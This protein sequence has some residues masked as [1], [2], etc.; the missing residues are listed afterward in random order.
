MST[1][2]YSMTEVRRLHEVLSA[3]F[4]DGRMNYEPP[5]EGV[6]WK[7]QFERIDD[8]L[9]AKEVANLGQLP[10]TALNVPPKEC[11]RI[12]TLCEAPR[13]AIMWW[14]PVATRGAMGLGGVQH[15]HVA[16]MLSVERG[17]GPGRGTLLFNSYKPGKD[18]VVV[19]KA[20]LA[21][22]KGF[23]VV[24]SKST[25][26]NAL[27]PLKAV[28]SGLSI[29]ADFR[30]GLTLPFTCAAFPPG[31]NGQAELEQLKGHLESLFLPLVGRSL[32][33]EDLDLWQG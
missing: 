28:V 6:C 13:P 18:G 20:E 32:T 31:V 19:V 26:A 9:T 22:L 33:D 21:L 11:A 8:K 10:L 17:E 16:R 15:H 30:Y 24:D 2:A 5:L 27:Q 4:I 12:K 1:T 29:V 23:R 14:E 3:A 25:Y 7:R